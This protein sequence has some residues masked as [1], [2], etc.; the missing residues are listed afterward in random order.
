[1]RIVNR[2]AWCLVVGGLL[3][4]SLSALAEPKKEI[5]SLTKEEKE[6]LDL[7]GQEDK[8]LLALSEEEQISLAIQNNS[9]LFRL[10]SERSIVLRDL[11]TPSLS[12]EYG[13]EII[14]RD[15]LDTFRRGQEES[16]YWL[17]YDFSD[18]FDKTKRARSFHSQREAFKHK[19]R[20]DVRELR[21]KI[22]L[23]EQIV[24]DCQNA[25]WQIQKDY[26]EL[27][28]QIKHPPDKQQ[29]SIKH[30]QDSQRLYSSLKSAE[31]ELLGYQYALVSLIRGYSRVGYIK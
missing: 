3:I 6:S 27:K 13:H 9:E 8:K 22:R 29:L 15:R 26:K 17:K 12:V 14:D 23:A 1:M 28:E 4:L 2:R 10:A 25:L 7:L 5:I 21:G 11:Y 31:Q 24:G 30:S 18:I 16:T 20:C 19:I